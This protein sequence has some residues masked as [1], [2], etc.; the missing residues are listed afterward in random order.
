[1]RIVGGSLRGLRL[2]PPG[3]GD[4]AAHLRPTADRTRE[5][6]FNLLVNGREGDLVRGARVLDLF[7]GSGALALEALSR[8]AEAALLVDQ[9]RPAGALARRNIALARMEGRARLLL[10]DATRLGRCEEPPFTLVFLDP[11]YGAALGEAALA[12]ALAGGWLTPGATLVWE[13]GGPVAPPPP[14]V[15]LERRRYGSATVT[16]CRLPPAPDPATPAAAGAGADE[17]GVP[18]AD[19]PETGAQ[20]AAAPDTVPAT[21]SPGADP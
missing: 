13:E 10:R 17:A 8:G 19:T 21:T 1:M 18:N 6:V 20:D 7:A 15:L 4:A 9:G 11:P 3:R 5:A 14:L 2:A 16:L 12:S